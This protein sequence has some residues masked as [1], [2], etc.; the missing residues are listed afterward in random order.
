MTD[1]PTL[2]IS[3]C[4]YLGR[5]LFIGDN[6]ITDES[7]TVA[8]VEAL[9]DDQ[10]ELRRIQSLPDGEPTYVNLG[11]GAKRAIR[12]AK[13][14]GLTVQVH[15]IASNDGWDWVEC[16]S[17][18]CPDPSDHHRLV[19]P[20]Q[21]AQPV[22]PDGWRYGTGQDVLDH[23]GPCEWRTHT[24]ADADTYAH[25]PSANRIIQWRPKP[26]PET[27]RVN[28]WEAVGRY[29]PDK[30]GAPFQ[31]DRVGSGNGA[32]PSVY[33]YDRQNNGFRRIHAPV[34]ADGTV[35]VLARGGAS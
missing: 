4:H 5:S 30:D 24:F 2:T 1:T 6:F 23:D 31:V 15:M 26:A 18:P 29:V 17:D 12:S 13:A 34:S 9:L 7:M 8:A 25:R 32:G 10:A 20:A 33:A 28:W 16:K 19:I 14:A 3:E 22:D 11:K 27:E 35:E 21:H